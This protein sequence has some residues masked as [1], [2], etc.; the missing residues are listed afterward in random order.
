M[1]I[2]KGLVIPTYDRSAGELSKL[3]IRRS[4]WQAG[5]KLP[6]YVEIAGSMQTPSVYG[7]PKSRP[8]VVVE[9]EI[10]AILLQQC[11]GDLCCSMALGGASKRPDAEGHRLLVQASA[12][13]FS[14]DVDSAGAIAYRW[15]REV[16]QNIKVCPP[17]VGKSPGDAFLRGIDLRGWVGLA[18]LQ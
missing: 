16:Y 17:P 1:W 9:S 13:V 14:L 5:D 7:D 3:K 18:L 6:K 10:D 2:P 12:I 4:D 8:I 15:W 11:A